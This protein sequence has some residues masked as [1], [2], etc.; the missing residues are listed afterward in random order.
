MIV[1]RATE[2]FVNAAL[3]LR[4]WELWESILWE[5]LG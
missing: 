3:C 1:T 4:G 5:W 2:T